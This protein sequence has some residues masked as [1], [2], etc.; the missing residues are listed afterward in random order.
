M[1]IK[2]YKGEGRILVIPIIQITDADWF[3]RVS[4]TA[5]SLEVGQ[6][7]L[8]ALDVIK[9]ADSEGYQWDQHA[10]PA[11]QKNSRY[12]GWRSFWQHNHFSF[13]EITEDG[14][15]HIYCPQKYED[16]PGALGAP[17]KDIYLPADASAEE[18]GRAVI[19]V[20]EVSEAYDR[21]HKNTEAWRRKTV[22]LLDDSI[23]T[24]ICPKDSHFEDYQ[25]CGAAEI[26]QCYAYLSEEGAEPSAEFFVGIA[27]ELGCNL[28]E[29]N[30]HASWERVYGK[31]DSFQM[32]EA[33]CG[34]FKLRAEMRSRSIHKT[35]YF[36]QM[37]EDLLLECGMH[38][39][40]PNRRK[41]TDEKLA[42]KF[43][44]FASSCSF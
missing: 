38:V 10:V 12:K 43:E 28:D 20:L 5:G 44:K 42:A 30:V 16:A 11:W 41:K 39:Y 1:L 17:L 19:D 18:I 22:E 24:V 6:A 32:E 15:Y 37:G 8:D 35:S 31:A 23:L 2:V 33:D 29:E 9:K 27:P 4:E 14:Q 3:A 13:V 26:Y 25:D 21:D 34:I 7:V 36:L 40:Q